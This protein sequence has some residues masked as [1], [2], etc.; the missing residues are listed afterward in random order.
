MVIRTIFP[1]M[2]AGSVPII[3]QLD[4]DRGDA[5]VWTDVE[6]LTAA[7]DRLEPVLVILTVFDLGL[8]QGEERRAA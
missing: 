3:F 6:D 7:F 1:E 2:T 8:C 4:H 5:S